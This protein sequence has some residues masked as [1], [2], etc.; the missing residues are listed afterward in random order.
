MRIDRPS[1][2]VLPLPATRLER[3]TC[4]DA[5]LVH[6]V[7]G[8]HEKTIQR[9]QQHRRR[10]KSPGLTTR[11]PIG[12]Y[13]YARQHGQRQDRRPSAF[14]ERMGG[15]TQLLRRLDQSFAPSP[16]ATGVESKQS[17]EWP[18]RRQRGRIRWRYQCRPCF[19]TFREVSDPPVPGCATPETVRF[20]IPG[21][22]VACSSVAP[23]RE[24]YSLR[25]V[26]AR[27]RLAGGESVSS[28]RVTAEDRS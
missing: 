11:S 23:V 4:R 9:H 26:M 27:P 1:L 22:L 19:K 14:A 12:R 15:P 8:G 6:L 2:H 3:I 18:R 21:P 20:R 24:G 13:G 10:Q 16:T 7:P 28:N 5:R 25:S 17:S